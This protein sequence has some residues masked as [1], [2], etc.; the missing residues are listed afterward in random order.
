MK[1]ILIS[2]TG[3]TDS[4]AVVEESGSCEVIRTQRT[5]LFDVNNNVELETV[6]VNEQ[7]LEQIQS[8][9]AE[10]RRAGFKVDDTGLQEFLAELQTENTPNNQDEEF[11]N[12]LLEKNA[13][14]TF[15]KLLER[16]DNDVEEILVDNEKLYQDTVTFLSQN[17]PAYCS[18]VKLYQGDKALLKKYIPMYSFI[19]DNYIENPLSSQQLPPNSVNE[20]NHIKQPKK[21]GVKGTKPINA[22]NS[23]LVQE[24]SKQTPLKFIVLVVIIITL[25]LASGVF[26]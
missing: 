22:S 15:E 5:G 2:Q 24:G 8:E 17:T 19:E 1:R 7:N 13:Q 18:L 4:F 25:L 3:D 14:M 6:E 26:S 9:V 23:S 16:L 12:T 20:E 21:V 10:L 11:F